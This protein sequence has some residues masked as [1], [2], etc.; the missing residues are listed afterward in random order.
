VKRWLLLALAVA[1]CDPVFDL[2]LHV[3]SPDGN[4]VAEASVALT[5][6]SDQSQSNNSVGELTDAH[7]VADVGGS[8]VTFPPC[9]ITVAKPSFQPFESSF[10]ALCNGDR[11]NCDRVKTIEVVLEPNP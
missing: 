6:C 7:G 2:T 8:G 4:A 10:D 11:E 3:T 1:G 5:D 9:N